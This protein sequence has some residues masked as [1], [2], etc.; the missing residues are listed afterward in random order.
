MS[1]TVSAA[2]YFGVDIDLYDVAIDVRVNDI[3]V[4]FDTK[5]GQLTVEVPAPDS[6]IDG[7]NTLSLITRFPENPEDNYNLVQAYQ[8]GAYVSATLFRQ[9]GESAKINLA[10]VLVKFTPDGIELA[11]TQNYLTNEKSN[12]EVVLSKDGEVLLKESVD[13]KSPF[14]R[15]AWQDGK[16]IENNQEN[17]NSLI[18]VYR[19]IHSAM[20]AKDVNKVEKLYSQRAKET[21]IAYSLSGE[22]EG[23][24]KISTGKDMVNDKLNLY[25]F[26]TDFKD[27]RLDVFAN[28]KMARILID[29]RRRQPIL[30]IEP[31]A[32]LNH[33]HKFSFYLN[34]DNQWVMIR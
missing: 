28:G 6:I 27:N 4:Y 5:K 14:P 1:S 25:Q 3:P 30:F 26:R 34:N 10:S 18:E 32:R 22:K 21:A 12:P 9:D 33:F 19:D 24:N 23:H 2:P 29:I 31:A 8:E 11:E 15:W 17:Y 7:A 13:I 16:N 20:A